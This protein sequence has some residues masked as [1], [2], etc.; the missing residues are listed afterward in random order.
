M[1]VKSRYS[2]ARVEALLK[3]VEKSVGKLAKKVTPYS[4]TSR[5]LNQRGHLSAK[6][7]SRKKKLGG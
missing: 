2:L 4:K 7:Y 6:L 5:V 1:T 3:R